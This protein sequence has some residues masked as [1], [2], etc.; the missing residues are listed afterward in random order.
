MALILGTRFGD[1]L[2][3]TGASDDIF[4]GAGADVIDGNGSNDAISGGNGDDT[5]QG[6]VGRD[7]LAGGQGRDTLS[8]GEGNDVLNGGPDSDV[9]IGG[10][11][12]D[13]LDGGGG[14]NR[15]TGG[16]GDDF[17]RAGE[18]YS[19]LHGGD[20]RDTLIGSADDD[21][22]RGGSGTDL[23]IGGGGGD[24]YY[25]DRFDKLVESGEVVSIDQYGEPDNGLFFDTIYASVS[26]RLPDAI[27]GLNLF[28][29]GLDRVAIGNNRDNRIVVSGIGDEVRALGGN[30]YI[31]S[32][33]RDQVLRGGDGNDS[34]VITRLSTT[35]LETE[36]GGYDILSLQ[37]GFSM[38]IARN[39]EQLE[40]GANLIGR[41]DSDVLV[42]I[43]G[44]DSTLAGRGGNDT[45][46]GGLG[47]D[48]FVFDRA[49]GADNVDTITDFGEGRGSEDDEIVL[50]R[51]VFD[52]LNAA[53]TDLDAAMFHLGA[54]AADAGDRIL[55]DAA[56]GALR[57]DA[58][59]SGGGEAVVFAYLENLAVIDADNFRLV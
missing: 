39:V 55:Y 58:D 5:L 36:D 17:M 40:G 49:L 38:I 23:L 35:V 59:G 47:A 53:G 4:G 8:G 45:L 54:E 42:S 34:Y 52:T 44:G 41:G 15:L 7:T 22:L 9:L 18:G 14:S 20:G 37:G 46:T 10:S 48:S 11:G 12:N 50:R 6:G 31:Y 16:D 19:Y 43:N 24:T 13:L 56:D 26:Y 21:Q 29:N 57:F 33:G 32:N 25:V 51:S 27:E 3:G 28:D 30:D 1:V 2:E